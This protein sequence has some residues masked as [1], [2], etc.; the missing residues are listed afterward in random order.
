MT[1]AGINQVM[2]GIMIQGNQEA[3]YVP[4]IVRISFL[5]VDF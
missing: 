2:I 1:A 5:E 4:S 3:A